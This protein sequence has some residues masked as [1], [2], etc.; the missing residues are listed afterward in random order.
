MADILYGRV[1][2]GRSYCLAKGTIRH[3][4]NK[5]QLPTTSCYNYYSETEESYLT[6]TRDK[7]FV[8]PFSLTREM[9]KCT[10]LMPQVFTQVRIKALPALIRFTNMG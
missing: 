9:K 3:D 6:I 4:Q 2:V 1:A 8:I 5:V 7:S 10:L